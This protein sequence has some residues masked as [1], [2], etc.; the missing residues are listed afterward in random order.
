MNQLDAGVPFQKVHTRAAQHRDVDAEVVRITVVEHDNGLAARTQ[1]TMDLP[2]G[3]GSIWSMVENAV[4]VDDVER[5]VGKEEAFR[6]GNTETA[7]Q[8]EQFEAPF[9]Q[10]YSSVSKIDAGIFCSGVGKL[11]A[12]ST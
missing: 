12:I 3:C 2:H 11:S 5:I 10:V 8:I 4:R 1:H 9:R 6:I 7:W